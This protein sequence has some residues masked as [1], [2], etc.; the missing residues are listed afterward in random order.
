MF[1]RSAASLLIVVCVSYMCG[2]LRTDLSL[3]M[4]GQD[5]TSVLTFL[6]MVLWESWGDE[7]GKRQGGLC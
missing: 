6:E 1:H 4:G 7:A 3:S 2:G 5:W